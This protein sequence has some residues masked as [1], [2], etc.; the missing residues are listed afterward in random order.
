MK[1][2]Q[3]AYRAEDHGSLMT[4]LRV[5]LALCARQQG[6]DAYANSLVA[7]VRADFPNYL[8]GSASRERLWYDWA[9]IRIL[10]KEAEQ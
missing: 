10:L 9:F 6:D 8:T 7:T 2:L 4:T 5:L 1:L 3:Q